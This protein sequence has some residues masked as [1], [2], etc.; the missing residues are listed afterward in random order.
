MDAYTH[1]EIIAFIYT[2]AKFTNDERS[3]YSNSLKIHP[4][5]KFPETNPLDLNWKEILAQA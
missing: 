1:S 2:E 5:K 3:T 4:M